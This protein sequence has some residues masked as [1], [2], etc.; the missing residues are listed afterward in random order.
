MVE[1]E[2]QIRKRRRTEVGICGGLIL[3]GLVGMGLLALLRTAPAKTSDSE[4]ALR[5]DGLPV[6]PE[7]VR[8]TLK[9]YGTALPLTRLAIAPQVS[10]QVT[11]MHPR[12]RVGEIVPEGD[13][14]FAI[15]DRDYRAAV[16]EATAALAQSSN[17]V[18][19]LEEELRRNQQRRDTTH[20][21]H[22]LAL[23]EF[24]RVQNLLES[25]EIGSQAELDFAEQSLNSAR[26]L[27][28]EVEKNLT[29]SPYLIGEAEAAQRAANSQLDRTQRQVERCRVRSP[30]R[31]R[32]VQ[33]RLEVGQIAAAGVEALLLAD[34]SVLEIRVPLD[35][36]EAHQ[37]LE[38]ESRGEERSAWFGQVKPVSCTVHWTEAPASHQWTG[39]LHRVEQLKM[40]TR[41]LDVVIRVRGEQAANASGFPLV[42]GMFCSVDV[43]GRTLSQI[44]R[45]PRW[46]VSVDQSVYKA[47]EGRLVT[48][49][50]RVVYTQEEVALVD[51]GLSEGDILIVTRLGNPLEQSLLDLNRVRPEAVL[52]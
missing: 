47:V 8:V 29:V 21:N 14:L 5:V 49:P 36:R 20:R 42:D 1:A 3:L 13:L 22:T 7:D 34:D 2:S 51:H 35:A 41:M 39:V 26:D 45:I 31:A 40:E 43:P 50:V 16:V 10:G 24:E 6:V 17:T 44:Y 4:P 33:S 19:R 46:T 28:D 38:F 18:K 48:Q 30:F 11:N 37:W 32:V 27:L 25:H 23:R 12:L 15:D 52:P 9:G